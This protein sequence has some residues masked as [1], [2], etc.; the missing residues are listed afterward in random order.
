MLARPHA[1]RVAETE[2]DADADR[3]PR[4][5]V[6]PSPSRAATV[7]SEVDVEWRLDNGTETRRTWLGASSGDLARAA[8][9]RT[10][11][12]YKGQKHYSGVYWSATTRTHVPYESRL[13]L[14]RLLRAD[15]DTATTAIVAQP[16]LL[17]AL[18]DGKQRRHV[19]D[20]LLL[21]ED[22][23]LVIDV[24]PL[25]SLDQRK[26][27]FTLDWTEKVVSSRGWRYEVA[28]EP[29]EPELS[30][31]RFLSGYRRDWLFDPALAEQCRRRT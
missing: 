12:W 18:V 6:R 30:N 16:F 4:S 1:V 24:K 19:P 14:T 22:G 29:A 2:A 13:E 11:R 3:M 26:V 20:Y 15:F 31:I 9:W 21:G 7:P 28:S 8:P 25:A 23:P 10:F 5:Q 17:R 27:S